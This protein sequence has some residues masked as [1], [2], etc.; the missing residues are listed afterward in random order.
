MVGQV[1]NRENFTFGSLKGHELKAT[2]FKHRSPEAKTC[3]IY[4]HSFNG[5]RL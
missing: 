4:L 5:S 2:F 3:V 1:G